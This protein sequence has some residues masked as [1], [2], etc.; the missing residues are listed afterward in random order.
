MTDF[1]DEYFR[2]P[3]K[4]ELKEAKKFEDIHEHKSVNIYKLIDHQWQWVMAAKDL[5]EAMLI[6]SHIIG[7]ENDKYRI[8]EPQ[9]KGR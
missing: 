3:T 8:G 5:K 7:D 4:Q 6:L 2:E 9:G 1:L